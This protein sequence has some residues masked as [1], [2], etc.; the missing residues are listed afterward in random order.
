VLKKMPMLLDEVKTWNIPSDSH[1]TRNT[2]ISYGKLG[3]GAVL[4]LLKEEEGGS[5]VYELRKPSN[6]ESAEATFNLGYSPIN[7]L[8]K[9]ASS[10]QDA[11]PFQGTAELVCMVLHI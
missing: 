4:L 6:P 9:L 1:V 3:H 2:G 7:R 11:Q 10:E 5:G 8:N